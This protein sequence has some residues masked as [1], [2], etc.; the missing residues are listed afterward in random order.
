MAAPMHAWLSGALA[1]FALTSTA[2]A[3]EGERIVSVGGDV[4]EI[5]YALGFGDQVVATDSTSVFPPEALDTPKVG[6]VRSLAAESV[7]SLS[8][9]LLIL[10]GAAGPEEVVRQLE[11][12][13]LDMLSF[14]AEY[15]I[16]AVKDKVARISER[17]GVEPRGAEIIADIE[18][19]WMQAQAVIA[20]V[21]ERPRALFFASMG[22]GGPRAAGRGT[23]AHAVMELLGVENAFGDQDGYQAL[24]TEAAVAADP[25]II[26]AMSHNVRALGGIEAVTSDPAIALTT[27]GRERRILAIDSVRVMSFGPRVGE[28]LADAARE[29]EHM[30]AES[31]A[32]I[33]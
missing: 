32:P 16:D 20:R 18:S 10:G 22:D 2:F 4:T 5:V 33:R 28:G 25:D 6:Y 9:T 30:L 17:L 19:D 27:A 15:S 8:P 21:D 14:E 1:A 29:L 31:D 24:S 11:S 23:S 3:Q 7:L 26:F 13:G 12:V